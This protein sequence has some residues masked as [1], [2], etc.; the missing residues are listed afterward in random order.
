MITEDMK[1][2]THDLA[3][4]IE[5]LKTNNLKLTPATLYKIGLMSMSLCSA[6]ALNDSKLAERFD[7]VMLTDV[8]ALREQIVKNYY[9]PENKSITITAG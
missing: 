9:D 4:L 8:D 6:T 5:M 2:S 1:I 3:S 7:K